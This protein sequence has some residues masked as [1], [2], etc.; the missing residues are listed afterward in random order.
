MRL[1]RA[2][3]RKKKYVQIICYN[4]TVTDYIPTRNI[5]EKKKESKYIQSCF[6]IIITIRYII[7]LLLLTRDGAC[8]LVYY[9][10]LRNDIIVNVNNIK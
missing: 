1:S 6:R 4:A 2:Y 5:E 9:I 7:L 10:L 8:V 3:D